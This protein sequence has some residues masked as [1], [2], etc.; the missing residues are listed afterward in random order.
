MTIIVS[1]GYKYLGDLNMNRRTLALMCVVALST[2]ACGKDDGNKSKKA[3]KPTVAS[4]A[5]LPASRVQELFKGNTLIAKRYGEDETFKVFHGKDGSA[6][7]LD[8]KKRKGKWRVKDD[9]AYCIEWDG[10]NEKCRFVANDGKGGLLVADESR[11]VIWT[12][13]QFKPGKP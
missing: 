8:G 7:M 10:K 11:K 6:Q 12:V 2:L 3:D 13:D 5:I 1:L 9:G 4:E